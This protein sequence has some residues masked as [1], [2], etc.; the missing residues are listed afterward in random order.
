VK[1]LKLPVPDSEDEDAEDDGSIPISAYIYVSSA[2]PQ[3]TRVGTKTINTP[4]PKIT[5]C[6]PFIFSSSLP[7]NSFITLVAKAVRCLPTSL[8]TS[9]M[10]WKFDRPGNAVKKPLMDKVGYDV[11][12]STIISC[13]KDFIIS[14]SMPPPTPNVRDVVSVSKPQ[15]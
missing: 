3:I 12:I 5:P 6:G 1:K 4:A 7:F 8:V 13:H 2:A 9:Q 11:M 15:R 10:E 14:I